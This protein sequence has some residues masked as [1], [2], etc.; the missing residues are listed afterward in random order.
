M[1]IDVVAIDSLSSIGRNDIGHHKRT[2]IKH[3]EMNNVI[4]ASSHTWHVLPMKPYETQ[5]AAYYR[6]PH[7]G[8][9]TL[10]IHLTKFSSDPSKGEG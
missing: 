5:I 2:P 9:H 8:A 10:K 7:N 4:N 1:S 6:D 3:I